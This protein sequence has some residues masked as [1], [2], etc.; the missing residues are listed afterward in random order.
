MELVFDGPII[1]VYNS[2]ILKEYCE[3]LLRPKFHLTK[4]I[5]DSVI[6]NLKTRGLNIEAEKN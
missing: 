4:D 6:E 2:E 3:V 1:P 5:V